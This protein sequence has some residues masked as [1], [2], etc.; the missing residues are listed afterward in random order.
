MPSRNAID[1]IGYSENPSMETTTRKSVFAIPA[2]SLMKGENR[3]SVVRVV[4]R[5]MGQALDPI[6]TLSS[7]IRI[8]ALLFAPGDFN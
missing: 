3:L 2:P 8:D 4:H 7:C 1:G 5:R 6:N